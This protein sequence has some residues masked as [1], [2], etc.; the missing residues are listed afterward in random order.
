MKSE[1]IL[2][3]ARQ[4]LSSDERT[5]QN[6]RQNP[7]PITGG[8]RGQA[9][10]L[11]TE[12]WSISMSRYQQGPTAETTLHPP[13]HKTAVLLGGAVGVAGDVLTRH[14]L[15]DRSARSVDSVG[16]A[17]DQPHRQAEESAGLFF[18]KRTAI[19]KWV[20]LDLRCRTDS[21]RARP[22]IS[23]DTAR[24]IPY[25]APMSGPDP[26]SSVTGGASAA[27]KLLAAGI[28]SYATILK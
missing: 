16:H 11:S 2:E 9:S 22:A 26:R 18:V 20:M 24:V 8:G 13:A 17:V 15:D 1:A 19:H 27:T 12:P 10:Q 7:C 14:S 3:N 28:S 23:E 6:P 5:H 21:A 25:L 4:I